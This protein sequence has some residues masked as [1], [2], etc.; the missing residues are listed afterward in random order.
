MYASLHSFHED[1]AENVVYIACVCVCV[2][3]HM[4]VPVCVHACVCVGGGGGRGEVSCYD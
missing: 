2:C 3:V 4:C 1:V